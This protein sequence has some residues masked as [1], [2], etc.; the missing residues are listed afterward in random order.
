MRL[1]DKPPFCKSGLRRVKVGA[2]GTAIAALILALSGGSAIAGDRCAL[3]HC[4]DGDTCTLICAG[5]RVKVRLHCIDAPERAQ[6]P[7]GAKSRDYLRERAPAGAAVELRSVTRDKYGRTVGVLLVDGVNLNLNQ[8]QA[9][10]AAAYP[11]Y[12]AEPVYYQAQDDAQAQRR[13]IWQ[14]DGAQQRPW[15]WRAEKKQ[16]R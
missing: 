2:G 5:E 16:G 14:Q 4:H 7:W 8:V 15:E 13:G 6:A 12:C 11:K 1:Y 10:W 9:G 3:D